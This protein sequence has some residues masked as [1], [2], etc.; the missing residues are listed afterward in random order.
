MS[1]NNVSLLW[2]NS[3]G[4][5]RVDTLYACFCSAEASAKVQTTKTEVAAADTHSWNNVTDHL[6]SIYSWIRHIWRTL[7]RPSPF[8]SSSEM[9]ILK[10]RHRQTCKLCYCLFRDIR[11]LR[12]HRITHCSKGKDMHLLHNPSYISQNLDAHNVYF[13]THTSETSENEILQE[14]KG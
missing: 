13:W 6:V 5:E 1:K 10:E 14:Q 4:S 8:L 11:R 9:R 7:G 12:W 3:T 2:I